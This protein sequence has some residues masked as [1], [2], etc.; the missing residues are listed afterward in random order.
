MDGIFLTSCEWKGCGYFKLLISQYLMHVYLYTYSWKQQ[1]YSYCTGHSL[2]A[3]RPLPHASPDTLL[4]V[5]PRQLPC[6]WNGQGEALAR[7]WRLKS[8]EKPD[9]FS[10]PLSLL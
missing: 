5:H 6:I 2:F 8:K 7:G 4:S 9:H 1:I 3:L 10:V